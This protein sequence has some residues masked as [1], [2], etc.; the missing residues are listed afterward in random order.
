MK[1]RAQV[2]RQIIIDEHVD[3]GVCF[4]VRDGKQL[5]AIPLSDQ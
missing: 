5:L 3:N 1:V 4:L 2:N